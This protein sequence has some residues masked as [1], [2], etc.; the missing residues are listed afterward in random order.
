MRGID[1]LRAVRALLVTMALF[2]VLPSAASAVT[3]PGGLQQ[4]APPNDCISSAPGSNCGTVVNGGL[5]Q[6]RSVAI[7]PGGANAYVASQAGSL[8]TFGRNGETGGLSFTSCIKD[9]TST[10]ACPTNSTVPLSQAAWVVATDD[11]VYV[12]SRNGNAISEFS[13]DPSTGGLTVLGCI[14]QTG[15]SPVAGGPACATAPG[16]TGVDRLALS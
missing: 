4:L 5:G 6:A 7:N 9:P 15:T 13:R 1:V 16:L 3:N 12:A 10:E 8:S 2:A 14:S 11:N